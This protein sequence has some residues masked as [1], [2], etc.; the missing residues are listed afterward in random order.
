MTD[1]GAII[2]RHR[3]HLLKT[4]ETFENDS[5]IE[6]ICTSSSEANNK[7]IDDDDNHTTM[8]T[9]GQVAQPSNNGHEEDSKWA[10]SKP[11]KILK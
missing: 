7:S 2:R 10:N 8:E 6:S 1:K 9:A 3:R 4:K 11:S 5:D